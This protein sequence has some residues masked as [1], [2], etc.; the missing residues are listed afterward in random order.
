MS[1]ARAA[2]RWLLKT[3]EFKPA[4]ALSIATS[5]GSI[6]IGVMVGSGRVKAARREVVGTKMADD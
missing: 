6:L 1:Y 3:P 5:W 2:A 4:I